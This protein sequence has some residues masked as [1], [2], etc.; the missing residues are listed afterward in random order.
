MRINFFLNHS[1]NM[2]Y[3]ISNSYFNYYNHFRWCLYL[4]MPVLWS[5]SQFIDT[6]N[7]L[8]YF[9]Y[10]FGDYI[11]FKICY[12]VIEKI[13]KIKEDKIKRKL[14]VADRIWESEIRSMFHVTAPVFRHHY[15]LNPI[16]LVIFSIVH[17]NSFFLILILS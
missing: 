10:L 4:V 14:I 3:Y 8:F 12:F 15:E 13:I 9:S 7:I 16:L 6:I 2:K 5:I 1:N 11:F 17:P